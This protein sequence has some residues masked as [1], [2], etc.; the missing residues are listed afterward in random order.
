MI[1]CSPHVNNI[2]ESLS[3]L[4]FGQRAKTIKNTAKAHIHR[5][6]EELNLIITKLQKELTAL[7]KYSKHLE[8]IIS[9]YKK[10]FN[11]EAA[12]KEVNYYLSFI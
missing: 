5:S 8:S 1:A 6:V 10:D 9:E 4:R 2:E 12:K 3:A 7:K 11:P